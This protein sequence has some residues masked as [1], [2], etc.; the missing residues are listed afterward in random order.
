MFDEYKKLYQ[1]K[2]IVCDSIKNI[3]FYG[4]EN[5]KLDVLERLLVPGLTLVE[6]PFATSSYD[7]MVNA[8]ALRYIHNIELRDSMAAYRGLIE[9]TKE[10]NTRIL[11]NMV[12]NTAEISR[13]VDFHDV[14]STDTAISF[15]VAPHVPDIKPFP[16]LSREQR[17]SLIF[18][19]ES[20]IIQA[21]SNL[22]RL[23]R[24]YSSN[25]VLVKMLDQQLGK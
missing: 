25:L 14:V 4:E 21:Q 18:F 24:L 19:Y 23:R 16:D 12:R 1:K 13:L 22:R 15:D 20:Y 17:G 2:I 7:Q 6:M 8:G 3:F 10:Y 9:I 11:D 5:K